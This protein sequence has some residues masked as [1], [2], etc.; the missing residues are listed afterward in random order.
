[1]KT[2]KDERSS[3][4]GGARRPAMSGL[5]ERGTSGLAWALTAGSALLLLLAVALLALNRDLGWRALSPHL[6]L[7]PGFAV[8]GLVVAGR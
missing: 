5:R 8:V 3:T 6:S 7:V 2:N 1:M 4:R